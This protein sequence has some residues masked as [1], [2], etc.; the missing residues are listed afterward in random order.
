MTP[1]VETTSQGATSSTTLLV[2]TD[3]SYSDTAAAV[4]MGTSSTDMSTW[5]TELGLA[6]TTEDATFTMNEDACGS[7]MNQYDGG[8]F[9]SPNYPNGYDNN[10]N[11]IWWLYSTY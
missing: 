5:P 10:L 2:S 4:T 1:A 7:G 9:S 3:I 8:T 6:S 11:C